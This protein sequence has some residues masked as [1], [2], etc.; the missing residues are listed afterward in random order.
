MMCADGLMDA[1]GRLIE[2]TKLNA[3]QCEIPE[4]NRM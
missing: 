1:G 2:I 3:G 4:N